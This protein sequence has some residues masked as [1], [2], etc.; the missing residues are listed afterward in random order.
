MF[1]VGE[2]LYY[3]TEF[4]EP[5]LNVITNLLVE[6]YEIQDLLASFSI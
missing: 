2:F 6:E 4:V 5:R 3:A 1:D